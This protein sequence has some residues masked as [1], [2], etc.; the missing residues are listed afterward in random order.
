MDKTNLNIINQLD[1]NAKKSTAHIGRDIRISQQVVDYRIKKLIENK[2]IN[3]FST[4]INPFALDYKIFYIGLIFNKSSTKIKEDLFD[5]L[6]KTGNIIEA[7]I[8]GSSFDVT[9]TLSTKTYSELEIFLDEL[10]L[11][12]PKVFEDYEI[13]PVTKIIYHPYNYL[14]S[15]N[16]EFKYTIEEKETVKLDQTDYNILHQIKDSARSSN[17]NIGSKIG[18]SYKTVKHRIQIMTEKGIILGPKLFIHPQKLNYESFRVM[19]SLKSFSKKEDLSLEQYIL[20]HKNITTIM[21]IIGGIWTYVLTIDAKNSE[22]LQEILINIRNK[23]SQIDDFK[24]LTIFKNMD[25][26]HFPQSEKFSTIKK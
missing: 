8:A 10:F 25:E 17:L 23:Y 3:Q 11:K 5:Y 22:K 7:T 14:D 24:T 12:F 4:I 19:L 26:D 6:E 18:V 2:I 15:N 16:D 9:L 13:Y 1:E 21:K 20:Q